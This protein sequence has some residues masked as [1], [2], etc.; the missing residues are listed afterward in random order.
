MI[1]KNIGQRVFCFSS[2]S[3]III[4][5]SPLSTFDGTVSRDFFLQIFSWIIFPQAPHNLNSAI[6]NFFFKYLRR[7]LQGKV[8]RQFQ[9]HQLPIMATISDCIHLK[10][11]N[12]KKLSLCTNPSTQKCLNKVFKTHL[13]EVF[14]LNCHRCRLVPGMHLELRIFSSNFRK[15]SKWP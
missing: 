9:R 6:S 11:N 14:S 1:V 4:R 5:W 8:H 15:T 12:K 7:Y 10:V 13:I 2:L 3:L